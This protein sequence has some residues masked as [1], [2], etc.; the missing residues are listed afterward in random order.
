MAEEDNHYATLS[1]AAPSSHSFLLRRSGARGV[2]GS[3]P[4]P[5]YAHAD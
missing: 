3:C 5:G 1:L 4:N 2:N